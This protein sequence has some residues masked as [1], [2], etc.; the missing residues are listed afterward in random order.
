M[1]TEP[2][3]YLKI[4]LRFCV[5]FGNSHEMHSLRK[6][7]MGSIIELTREGGSRVMKS[8]ARCDHGQPGTGR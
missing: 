1:E 2:V 5:E 4:H 6:S 8:K 3:V 7:M